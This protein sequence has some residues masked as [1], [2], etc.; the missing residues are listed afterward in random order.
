MSETTPLLAAP[1]PLP[2]VQP[3]DFADFIRRATFEAPALIGST[4]ASLV[5]ELPQEERVALPGHLSPYLRP[6]LPTAHGWPG[7]GWSA[8]LHAS[9]AVHRVDVGNA[10]S[11]A[12]HQP[13]PSAR[14][15]YPARVSL[16]TCETPGPDGLNAGVYRYDSRHHAL[17][18]CT[19]SGLQRRPL[20]LLREQ[21]SSPLS[22]VFGG[23]AVSIDWGRTHAKY[24]QFSYRLALLEAGMQAAQLAVVAEALG[25]HATLLWD[26][27]DGPVN[28]TL[29]VGRHERAVALVLLR[30]EPGT[31]QTPRY[32]TPNQHNPAPELEPHVR[33]PAAAELGALDCCTHLHS[34]QEPAPTGPGLP[35]Q[36][37]PLALGRR[38]L[39]RT[40][41]S[42]HSGDP[43]FA[44]LAEDC[45][46]SRLNSLLRSAAQPYPLSNGARI[47]AVAL[48]AVYRDGGNLRHLRA[49]PGMADQV[50]PVSASDLSE[51]QPDLPLVHAPLTVWFCATLPD[52]SRAREYR[53][54]N[55]EVGVMAQRLLLLAAEFGWAGRA[56]CSYHASKAQAALGLP[57][58]EAPLLQ[59]TFGREP[60]SRWAP[61]RYRLQLRP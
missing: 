18:P 38:D 31:V 58:D 25:G 30:H 40:I 45:G 50:C 29:G 6:L 36:V 7:R 16:L 20:D 32:Q 51:V 12:Q 1:G 11:W 14:C 48:H 2:A 54:L 55:L 34:S 37:T 56:S 21:L 52:A 19:G 33:T 41:R 60:P 49:A 28:L 5:P 27:P 9:A 8:W 10:V 3:G 23:A 53:R 17:I 47:P 26:F 39:L 42:R 15:L 4:A 57:P 43:V 59:L 24:G 22:G 61:G 44:P 13:T 46:D 35:A